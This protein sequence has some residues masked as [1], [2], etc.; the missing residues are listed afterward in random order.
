MLQDNLMPNHR[1]IIFGATGNFGD[2]TFEFLSQGPRHSPLV[3]HL[4]NKDSNAI[5]KMGCYANDDV[6]SITTSYKLPQIVFKTKI[7]TNMISSFPM[8]T[9]L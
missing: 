4:L 9:K 8:E 7:L 6:M 3:L 1:A 2:D 5:K